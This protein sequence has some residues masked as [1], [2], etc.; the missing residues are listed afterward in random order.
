MTKSFFF[1]SVVS[2]LLLIAVSAHAATPEDLQ[3]LVTP[4]VPN[5]GEAITVTLESIATDLNQAEMVWRVNG[6]IVARGK[7]EKIIQTETAALGKETAVSVSVTTIDSGVIEKTIALRPARVDLLFQADSY[8]PPFYRG[9]ALAPSESR[10]TAVAVPD[11]LAGG[12]RLKPSEIIFTWKRNGTVVGSRSGL[13]KNTYTF[14]SG[15]I[16]GDEPTIEVEALAPA[17]NLKA[18]AALVVPLTPPFV[19]FY[20]EHPLRGVLLGEALPPKIALSGSEMTLV[21]YPYFVEKSDNENGAIDYEWRLNRGTVPGGVMKNSITVRSPG[22][23]GAALLSLSVNNLRK[24]FESGSR[25]VTIEFGSR[26]E[27][28]L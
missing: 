24:L 19:L 8:T 13:G 12:R 4:P 1:L 23:S 3:M 6:K 2:C 5:E 22:G 16:R 15:R 9:K 7:G 10:L 21:A 27:P 20:E 26:S 25:N 11:F 17:Y 14:Q 28:Q 18:R